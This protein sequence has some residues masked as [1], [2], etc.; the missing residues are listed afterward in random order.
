MSNVAL[1]SVLGPVKKHGKTLYSKPVPIVKATYNG[2]ANSV[3]IT[4]GK[5]YKGKAQFNFQGV[6][7]AANGQSSNRSFSTYVE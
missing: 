2:A 3:T 5:P 7:M 4:L 1:Y 6:V